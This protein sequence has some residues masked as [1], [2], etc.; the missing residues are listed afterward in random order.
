M[1]ERSSLDWISELASTLIGNLSRRGYT[2]HESLG[3]A[4]LNHMNGRVQD[5]ILGRFL[6]AD[7]YIPE[8]GLTQAYNR[9]SYVYNNPLRFTD[10]SG[11][12]VVGDASAVAVCGSPDTPLCSTAVKY[13]VDTIIIDSGVD[14]VKGVAKI[15]KKIFGGLFGGGKPPPPPKGCFVTNP[16]A[17]TGVPGATRT[18]GFNPMMGLAAQ[19]AGVDATAMSVEQARRGAEGYVRRQVGRI[20]S[21][22]PAGWSSP[23]G[24]LLEVK[25]I[26]RGATSKYDVEVSIA[27]VRDSSTG[28]YYVDPRS[29]VGGNNICYRGTVE[30]DVSP[31]LGARGAFT[32]SNVN[33]TVVGLIHT[34]PD[35]VHGWHA[36]DRGLYS[37]VYAI[38]TDAALGAGFEGYIIT[39]SGAVCRYVMVQQ[40]RQV[41]GRTPEHVAGPSGSPSKGCNDP[42]GGFR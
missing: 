31:I 4:T 33:A 30:C 9:Y 42:S 20:L 39:R 16:T 27:I 11:F 19:A 1:T 8:P 38:D 13:V 37:R 6:S 26:L 10:P 34:H 5:P 17:C 35:D 36:R 7:P 3:G 24:V 15:F 14:I 40:G 28:R 29:I 22:N 2:F 18:P 12:T 32:T 21:G 41:Y 23:L 25:D